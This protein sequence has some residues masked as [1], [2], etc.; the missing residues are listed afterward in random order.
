MSLMSF[1]QGGKNIHGLGKYSA[2][3]EHSLRDLGQEWGLYSIRSG[4]VEMGHDCLGGQR[5]P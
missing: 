1:I 3:V 4:N 2:L 5:F